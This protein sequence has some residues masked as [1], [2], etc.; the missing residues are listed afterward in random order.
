[1]GMG[2]QDL[3]F[4]AIMCCDV[5]IRKDLYSNV[6]L[7]G[8]TSLFQ[9]IGERLTKDLTSLAPSSMRVRVTAPPERKY[10]TW[11]GGAILASLST[12]QES[13]ITKGD[14]DET[15]PSVVARKCFG[16]FNGCCPESHG[17]VYEQPPAPAVPSEP[18]SSP[19]ES[20]D[21]HLSEE[22]CA[23]EPT[24]RSTIVAQQAPAD[25]NV[26]VTQCGQ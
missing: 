23:P 1:M 21:A 9:G 26:L 19:L 8:G 18:V 10:S 2:I 13:L 4:R 15:G 24:K 12:F 7:S 17:V 11:I 5:D 22:T 6:V 25:T 3:A 16:G 14:Y 20:L